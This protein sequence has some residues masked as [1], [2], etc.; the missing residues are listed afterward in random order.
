MNQQDKVAQL[1]MHLDG[2]MARLEK[3]D[4]SET[5]LQDIDQLINL[6]EKMEENLK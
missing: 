6:V 4:P 3:M 5:S 2:F 1:K